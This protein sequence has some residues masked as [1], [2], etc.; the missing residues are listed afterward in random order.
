MAASFYYLKNSDSTISKV[1]DF[2]L[3]SKLNNRLTLYLSFRQ[4]E[5]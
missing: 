2:N 1:F 3:I 5:H 4:K